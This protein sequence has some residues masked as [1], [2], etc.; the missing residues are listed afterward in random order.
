MG[1]IKQKGDRAQSRQ[2]PSPPV[3]KQMNDSGEHTTCLSV[4]SR[5]AAVVES[6]CHKVRQTYRAAGLTGVLHHFAWEAL[7]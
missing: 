2:C 4:Y 3:S 5:M 6:D 1:V 7:A